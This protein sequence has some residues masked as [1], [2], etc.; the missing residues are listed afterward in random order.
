MGWGEAWR[1]MQLLLRD[2][3]SR[4][5]AA[6]A[7]WEAPRSPE[8]MILA[9]LFDLT[10]RGL[11]GRKKITPYPR[12]WDKRRFGNARKRSQ[13]EIRAALRARGHGVALHRRDSNG[14]LRDER[15]RYV[16]EG[17]RG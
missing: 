15:G 5:A 8:W 12:P 2:P 9:D 10:H 4:L 3:S 16:K 11:A 14:R 13:G 7:G 1:L 17:S 6:V